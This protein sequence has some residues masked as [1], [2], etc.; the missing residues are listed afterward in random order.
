MAKNQIRHIDEYFRR[1]QRRSRD[2][3]VQR[4]GNRICV[5]RNEEDSFLD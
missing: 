5:L 4:N 2:Y 1:K 3:H